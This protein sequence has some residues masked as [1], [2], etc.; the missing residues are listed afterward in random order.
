MSEYFFELLTEEI[1]AWMLPPRLQ[2]L[3]DALSALYKD[4]SERSPA[5][6]E[7]L[8]DATSRRIYFVLRGLPKQQADR[9]EEVKGP[10]ARVAFDANGTPTNALLGFLKKNA[11]TLETIKTENDYVWLK[12]PVAG[13]HLGD[14]L[15]TGI[16][17]IIESLR[18]PKMMRWGAGKSFIRPVHSIISILETQPLALQVFGIESSNLTAGHRTLS[19]AGIPIVGAP[20]VEAPIVGAHGS[21][22]AT[23]AERQSITVSG[24][25]DYR[26]KLR[27]AHVVISANERVQIM[28]DAAQVLAAEV[29]GEPAI[30][31]QIWDQ[32]RFLSEAPMLV[33]STFDEAYLA[34]PEEVL[35]TVMRVHQKQLPIF[36]GGKLT[37]SFLAIVDMQNDD[38]GNARYGNA[39]VTSA[40][41]ADAQFFY[42]ADRRKKLSDRLPEIARLQFQEKLGHYLDKTK[43]IAEIAER[44]RTEAR[45]VMDATDLAT[46]ATLCKSDLVTEMVKEFTEL[47]GKVGGIYARESG[48]G[49]DVWM[50]IYDHYR[51]QNVE[52][53]LP[54]TASGA[55]L[56][57]ADKIDTVAGFFSVG[58]KPSGSKDPFAL[59]R[60]AQGIVQILLARSAWTIAL[61]L[62][63]LID[64]ALDGYRMPDE[65]KDVL[66]GELAEFFAERVRSLLQ[67]ILHPFAYDEILAAMAAGWQKSLPDLVDRIDA[68]RAARNSRDFLSLLDSARR[69]ANIA[70]QAEGAADVNPA[71]LQ[72]S[73]EQRLHSL[74]SLVTEQIGE[75]VAARKYTEAFESF[76]ALAPELEKFFEHVMVMVEDPAIRANRI[77]LLKKVG[78]TVE[79]IADLAQIVVARSDYSGEPRGRQ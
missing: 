67:G 58:L 23:P 15:V 24:Y 28:Q 33:R 6:D 14:A 12:R 25:D 10:A 39:F 31:E 66:R 42:E 78:S 73:N 44:I 70:A 46:A 11:A 53:E 18:W 30:D 72:D 75:L 13:R 37:N 61:P 21:V 55:I 17:K 52:D 51:P 34:L 5:D 79:S 41:F 71:L 3:R 35:I 4:F 64:F 32:W 59:R 68:L 57:I 7:I 9:M 8:V 27:A 20:I 65:R 47:Q 77:A 38:A 60:A 63:R 40:R 74:S 1:P 16:P 56:S 54:R 22:P 49:E 76:A 50:A 43:R 69:I 36:A 48:L 19:V 29:G 2:V 26:E 45:V 62:E